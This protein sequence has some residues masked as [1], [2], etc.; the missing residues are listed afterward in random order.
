MENLMYKKTPKQIVET[1]YGDVLKEYEAY[2]Y[3]FTNLENNKKYVGYHKG[4]VGDGYWNSSTCDVFKKVC[5][6]SSSRLRYEILNYGTDIEFLKIVKHILQ[7]KN[8]QV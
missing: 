8:K 7:L 5:T 2:V 4:S 6:D 3:R 1:N